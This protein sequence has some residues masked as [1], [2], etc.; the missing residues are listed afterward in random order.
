MLRRSFKR[1][2]NLPSSKEAL[3]FSLPPNYKPNKRVVKHLPWTKCMEIWLRSF[4]KGMV[5]TLQNKLVELQVNPAKYVNHDIRWENK[6]VAV[7]E[8][9]NWI[10][11]IVFELKSQQDKPVKHVVFLHGY[12]AA[13]GCFA[14]NF[15]LIN[16]FKD[17]HYNYK[18]HFL[19]NITFGLSSNPKMA[20]DPLNHNWVEKC[21]PIK[22]IDNDLPTDSKK[23][24]K[25][26]Y[27]LVDEYH[28]DTE[29]FEEY[30][31]TFKPIVKLLEDFYCGAIDLWRKNS[32]IEKIDYLIGHSYGGYWS[33]SYAVRYPDNF[34]NLVLLSPVG[35]E[36]H[37]HA[38]TNNLLRNE[39][40]QI[41]NDETLVSLKPSLDPTS[42]NFLSRIPILGLKHINYWYYVQ[43]FL[44]RLLKWLGPWGVQ[45]YYQMWY[46]KLFK[47]NKV[48]NSLGG[49]AKLFK[50]E[51][52]LVY[53]TNTE[54]RLLIEY[55]Y[56]T[57]IQ[58]SNSDIYIK[59]L[60]TPSTVSKWPLYDKY[61]QYFQNGHKFRDD[62]K[63]TVAY[64]QFD[65]MNAEAGEKLIQLIQH[66]MVTPQNAKVVSIREGG[67]NLYI[68]NPFDTNTLLHLIVAA[69]DNL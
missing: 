31:A 35:V 68:D 38:V 36:R 8:Q 59:H 11:E 45:K 30:Q 16:L 27:K 55:L 26:Y 3:P 22:V 15:Q 17:T 56:N 54:V 10:N 25:K 37:C 57:T 63:I 62:Q 18:I 34:Q 44:P 19:D 51:N 24:Y 9:G 5:Q 52:D 32:G 64:G 41:T 6:K 2:I 65:F 39:G 53:G 23:L 50:S 60:L 66:N 7:D 48:I 47:I 58:G 40:A 33:G 20:N 13:L 67:H 12:G 46:L 28:V 1:W 21:A 29:R 4:Q 61:F 42:Y 69:D 43:P 49:G 14:R